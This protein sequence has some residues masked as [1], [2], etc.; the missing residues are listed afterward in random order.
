[1]YVVR[2]HTFHNKIHFASAMSQV[3]M[4]EIATH[5]QGTITSLSVVKSGRV[6][7]NEKQICMYVCMW[8]SLFID[9]TVAT[10]LFCLS[11]GYYFVCD[12]I[13]TTLGIRAHTH[14]RCLSW[15]LLSHTFTHTCS[16][17][18]IKPIGHLKY[19][20]TLVYIHSL[21]FSW[22]HELD[23]FFIPALFNI[24]KFFGFFSA[25]QE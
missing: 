25:C 10:Y 2:S 21:R 18:C 15:N 8:E 5:S 16:M 22:A 11:F 1:M 4:T 7:M 20:P 19:Y 12:S 17:R 13:K 23:I 9:S 24:S 6:K 3:Y 14:T